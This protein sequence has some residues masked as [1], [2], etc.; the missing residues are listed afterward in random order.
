MGNYNITIGHD[1]HLC[2][3]LNYDI[4]IMVLTSQGYQ[5]KENSKVIRNF[6]VYYLIG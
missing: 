2:C 3:A 5:N 6:T 4:E 1:C